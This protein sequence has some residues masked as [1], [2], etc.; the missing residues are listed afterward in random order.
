MDKIII[1]ANRTAFFCV[2]LAGAVGCG[3]GADEEDAV[4]DATAPALCA[5]T[6]SCAAGEYCSFPDG[7]C[8]NNEEPGHCLEKPA[9]C[10]DQALP[11]CG[12]DGL[13]YGNACFAGNDG[14]NVLHDGECS[15][16][17]AAASKG[18]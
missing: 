14:I 18:G 6:E 9:P 16:D 12:C 8:G 4:G 7:S 10:R 2:M 3:G 15:D 1:R 17:G 5:S 13:T 11:V